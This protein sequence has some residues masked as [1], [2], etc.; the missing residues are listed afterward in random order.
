MPAA[1]DRSVRGFGTR[2]Q[3]RWGAILLL[4]SCNQTKRMTTPLLLRRCTGQRVF[5]P[6]ITPSPESSE[7]GQ[8]AQGIDDS[9]ARTGLKSPDLVPEAAKRDCGHYILKKEF[10]RFFGVSGPNDPPP[11]GD[12]RTFRVRSALF[13]AFCVGP[14]RCRRSPDYPPFRWRDGEVF[15]DSPATIVDD[16][17]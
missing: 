14:A 15:L 3:D 9:E 7:E 13:F 6:C 2:V 12:S 5:G 10:P 1:H 17:T 11:L 8:P 16:G 4:S